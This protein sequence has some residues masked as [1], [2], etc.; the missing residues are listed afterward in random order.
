MEYFETHFPTPNAP[1][2]PQTT[3]KRFVAMLL[4]LISDD[5]MLTQATYWRWSP[6]NLEKQKSFLEY[7]FGDSSTGGRGSFS[8]KVANGTKVTF[9]LRMFDTLLTTR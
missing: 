8:E 3:T 2:I 6:E 4:E 5:W 1:L 9:A 7:E